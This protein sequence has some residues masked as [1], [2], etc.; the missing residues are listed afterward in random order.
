MKTPIYKTHTAYL[1][2]VL[3]LTLLVMLIFSSNA[4]ADEY[5]SSDHIMAHVGT[6]YLINTGVYGL[7]NTT[8]DRPLYH[9]NILY[10]P[11]ELRDR[12][13]SVRTF[14]I[15]SSI[16]ITLTAGFIYKYNDS[17]AAGGGT[18][19]WSKVDGTKMMLWNAVGVGLSTGSILVFKF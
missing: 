19:G 11:D 12:D 14:S 2:F 4:L 17:L 15:V 18:K 8:A 9:G 7:L 16:I 13:K 10:T 5:D 1:V 3:A 6:S